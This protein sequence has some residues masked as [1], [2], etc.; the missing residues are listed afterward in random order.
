MKGY[1][2]AVTVGAIVIPIALRVLAPPDRMAWWPDTASMVIVGG[3]V[4]VSVVWKARIDREWNPRIWNVLK[5]LA[6]RSSSN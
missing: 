5:A 3:A 1:I 2:T 6:R 4:A